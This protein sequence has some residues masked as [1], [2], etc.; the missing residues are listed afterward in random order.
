MPET[1]TVCCKISKKM[2]GAFGDIKNRDISSEKS[3][4]R[5]FEQCHSAEK[6][7]K[8]EPFEIFQH[9]FCCKISNKLRGSFGAI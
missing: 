9:P 7:K 6:L 2:K 4:N 5:I 1:A 3:K 8:R